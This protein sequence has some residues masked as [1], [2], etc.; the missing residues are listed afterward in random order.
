MFKDNDMDELQIKEPDSYSNNNADGRKFAIESGSSVTA[1]VWLN[2]HTKNNEIIVKD[3]EKVID[4]GED[5][6]IEKK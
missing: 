1:Y 6:I 2:K 4:E 3:K 5:N